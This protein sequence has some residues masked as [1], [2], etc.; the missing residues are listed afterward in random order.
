VSV[1]LASARLTGPGVAGTPG[2][3]GWILVEGEQIVDTGPGEPSLLATQKAGEIIDL[4]GRRVVPGFV[5]AHCHGGGGA[6]LYSGSVQDVVTAARAHLET[7]TTSMLASV[8]SMRLDAMV[9][10]VNA[11]ADAI[12]SGQAPNIVGIHLEGPFLS[13]RRRGAQTPSALLTPD[14]KV[15][16]RLLRAGRGHV[17][18]MTIAPELPGAAEL[19][20]RRSG[21]V[22]FSLGHT[23]ADADACEIGID[24]GARTVTHLF[25]AMRPL[26]HREPGAVGVA[27][28]DGRVAVEVVGDGHHLDDLVLRMTVA[29]AGRDRVMAVTD[30]SPAAGLGDG[31]YTFADR[32]VLV[33]D[34]VARLYGTDTIAGSAVTLGDIFTRLVLHADFGLDDAVALTS[35]T[36]AKALGLVDRGTLAPG[37]R[38]HL[39]V[40]DDGLRAERV[41]LAGA[42][43]GRGDTSP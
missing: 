35:S 31:E 39:V 16:D 3:I 1:L 27:L 24:A 2:G 36:P 26:L 12:E 32:H 37:H 14:E 9:G 23:D 42:W 34:G 17:R 11:I 5:D 25:N 7:G 13:P 18:T 10:A 33:Q 30:A 6:S 15:L 21:D 4:A 19:I 29:V 43:I 40:L 41:M 38:A 20:N 28:S 22:L 8:A